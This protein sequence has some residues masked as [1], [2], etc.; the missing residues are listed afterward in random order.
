MLQNKEIKKFPERS[1]KRKLNFHGS[2][3]NKVLIDKYSS[4]VHFQLVSAHFVIQ[5]FLLYV[6][7]PFVRP[8]AFMSL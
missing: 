4:S 6:F 8:K 2:D 5:F 3:S 7:F 1:T